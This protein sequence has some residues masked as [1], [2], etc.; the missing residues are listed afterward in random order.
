MP[1]MLPWCRWLEQTSLGSAVRESLW[2]FPAI[3]TL[4][5]LGMAALLGT[6]AVFDLRLLGWLM[7]R[8]RVSDLGKRLL[9]WTWAA[10][11]LQVITGATLFM[12]EAV[13]VYTNPA[14]RLKM[15][16]ILLAGLQALIFHRTVYRN[17]VTWGDAEVSPMRAKIAGL[18]SL[19]LWLAVVA[20]GRFIGFV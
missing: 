15:L 19:L 4:H 6:I 1:D 16:L 5:L 14:F 13:K 9:P 2:L 11:A 18:V 10:F 17:G 20:A 3:E 12:S 7:P 8:Q